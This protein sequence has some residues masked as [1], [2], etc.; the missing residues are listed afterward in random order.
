MIQV[1]VPPRAQGALS[2]ETRS[3]VAE[4][5]GEV[6]TPFG[7]Y[8]R[9]TFSYDTTPSSTCHR[10]GQE[11][12]HAGN[13]LLGYDPECAALLGIPR[14]Y[15]AE[16][17]EEIR[18]RLAANTRQELWIPADSSRNPLVVTAE[19]APP[20][21]KLDFAYHQG[22]I[23][24]L[25]RLS[26]ARWNKWDRVWE[27]PLD[28][29]LAQTLARLAYQEG[30]AVW[31]E[32]ELLDRVLQAEE[33][34]LET[35]AN[36]EPAQPPKPEPP[37][38]T[39]RDYGKWVG[40]STRYDSR[41][42]E[43]ARA[44]GGEWNPSRR[45]WEISQPQAALLVAALRAL[46]W[47]VEG[48]DAY[49]E[50]DP[51]AL[52]E[53]L[54]APKKNPKKG[55]ATLIAQ[56]GQLLVRAPYGYRRALEEIGG[57]YDASL[58]ARV[59]PAP[60]R[61]QVE[62]I[63]AALKA[64]VVRLEGDW[65]GLERTWA[66]EARPQEEPTDLPD[67]PHLKTKPWLHQK[68]GFH[69]LMSLYQSGKSGAMLAFDMG[70]G[71]TLTTIGFAGAAGFRRVLVGA[72]RSAV[73]NW[74]REFALHSALEWEYARLNQ[75]VGSVADKLVEAQAALARA[76]Q[77]GKPLVVAVN[78]ESMVRDPLAEWLLS[79]QWDLLVLDESHKLKAPDGQRAQFMARLA[80]R[81]RFRLGLTGTPM[82]HSPLDI[83]AQ[84]RIIDP[85][86]F[87]ER[88]F[89]FR[90]RYALLD[91]YNKP[92]GYRHLDELHRRFYTRALRVTKAE[93]LDL[94]AETHQRVAVFLSPKALRHYRELMEELQTEI[95]QQS[96]NASNVLVK[97]LR[98]QQ[99]T[100]GFLPTEKGALRID[101]AKEEAL[102]DLLEG[103]SG[104]PV[105]VFGRF[106]HDLDVVHAV[107]QR[108]GCTSGELSG[109]RDQWEAFQFD[110]AFDVLAV[111]IQAGG[112]GIN[113]TRAA[114]AIYYSMG[115]SLGDYLQSLARIHRPGQTRP[116]TYYHLV[117]SGT[118][119][120]QVYAALQARQ[121]LVEAAL[122]G[123]K[124]P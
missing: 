20:V 46:G 18:Q 13:R 101:H 4:T 3:L 29:S 44:L 27:L 91:E 114:Y 63:R 84:M 87:G 39:L 102:E 67:I 103:L 24:A 40:L 47:R 72:P 38:A 36:P 89:A 59:Y 56:P 68:R 48:G 42:V 55:V 9:G 62:E 92:S 73:S 85:S 1:T 74:T 60:S 21:L 33:V 15:T 41:V 90:R 79:Q 112:V 69:F 35:L 6:P 98:I 26:V 53:L 108:L 75:E 43:V 88:F 119:D 109:E 80:H 106:R 70:A 110:K 71:K 115:F 65:E 5:V 37:L 124:A 105:V 120:E 2:L 99:I 19:E 104:E 17:V 100:S 30:F 122:A 52:E 118:I 82:P 66:E 94:P 95:E 16:E 123:R 81:A 107:C 45:E 111:Q 28:Y 49:G 61:E 96:I 57:E 22:L 113:L 54:A 11:I 50:A 10:C 86:L 23:E 76:E 34:P 12:P 116:V 14:Q 8:L 78:Y 77:S 25:R 58:K 31:M 117:A 93:A 7:V 64:T 121:D 83:W 97:L 32:R 51:V